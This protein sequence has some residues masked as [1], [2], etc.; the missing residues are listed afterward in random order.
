MT[1]ITLLTRQCAHQH[2]MGCHRPGVLL[3]NTEYATPPS[4]AFE[5]QW[6]RQISFTFRS[7]RYPMLLE[8]KEKCYTSAISSFSLQYLINDCWGFCP[9][10][11]AI[12]S[13]IRYILHHNS[14]TWWVNVVRIYGFAS[15]GV[16]GL[17]I[18]SGSHAHG[19]SDVYPLWVCDLCSGLVVWLWTWG[20]Q[21][22]IRTVQQVKH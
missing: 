6:T 16:R 10:N 13:S 11:Q 20:R 22:Q 19:L 12:L 8:R 9:A 15:W 5:G 4:Q 18:F 7:I 2:W 17:C 1:L 3:W 14:S 21:V